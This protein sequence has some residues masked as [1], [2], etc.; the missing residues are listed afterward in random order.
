MYLVTHFEVLIV[1]SARG[2]SDNVLRPSRD[3]SLN[4]I[5]A[6]NSTDND[7]QGNDCGTE[8]AYSESDLLSIGANNSTDNDPQ[9]NDCGTRILRPRLKVDYN[10][11]KESSDSESDDLSDNLSFSSHES[12]DI[13]VM[14]KR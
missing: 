8:S 1:V 9:G 13:S 7:P 10:E 11:N 4:S 14:R 3:G 2:N 12:S 6:N 5:G